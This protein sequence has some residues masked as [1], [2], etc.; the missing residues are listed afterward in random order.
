MAKVNK[1]KAETKLES[2]KESA[3]KKANEKAEDFGVG[4]ESGLKNYTE[5][6]KK[7]ILEQYKKINRLLKEIEFRNKKGEKHSVTISKKDASFF[8]NLGGKTLCTDAAYSDSGKNA[9][10]VEMAWAQVDGMLPITFE[11]VMSVLRS[12]RAKE[13]LG[14]CKNNVKIARDLVGMAHLAQLL[15]G[16][17]SDIQKLSACLFYG[18]DIDSLNVMKEFFNVKM[19]GEFMSSLE[20][21]QKTAKNLTR[22]EM[23]MMGRKGLTTFGAASMVQD[24]LAEELVTGKEVYSF[25]TVSPKLN[26]F[27]NIKPPIPDFF[28]KGQKL[29]ENFL[30][31]KP[32][33]PQQLRA[34]DEVLSKEYR[35]SVDEKVKTIT[36]TIMAETS[37]VVVKEYVNYDKYVEYK[38]LTRVKNDNA[39]QLNAFLTGNFHELNNV[40]DLLKHAAALGFTKEQIADLRQK[41]R[42]ATIQRRTAC[43]AVM[44]NEAIETVVY[45]NNYVEGG[46]KRDGF[47]LIDINEKIEE[48]KKNNGITVLVPEEV[49]TEIERLMTRKS[50]LEDCMKKGVPSRK[51]IEITAEEGSFDWIVQFY[52]AG[53]ADE[54]GNLQNVVKRLTSEISKKSKR[55]Q[56]EI[57][58]PEVKKQ[59]SLECE[60][61]VKYKEI[62]EERLKIFREDAEK[63]GRAEKAEKRAQEQQTEK[64]EYVAPEVGKV[65][66]NSGDSVEFMKESIPKS[67]V[68]KEPEVQKTEGDV[69]KEIEEAIKNI[70][71]GN[72]IA[73]IGTVFNQLRDFSNMIKN[74]DQKESYLQFIIDRSAELIGVL[75]EYKPNDKDFN[76]IKSI[77]NLKQDIEN[78]KK[79]QE[80]FLQKHKERVVGNVS[81][82]PEVLK[83]N[84]SLLAPEEE[85]VTESPTTDIVAEASTEKKGVEIGKSDALFD[86]SE[87]GVANPPARGSSL[88]AEKKKEEALEELANQIGNKP[89]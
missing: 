38:V 65:E 14:I 22:D 87:N 34:I 60:K 46:K 59:L 29:L 77:R 13:F 50:I 23:K 48:F 12:E 6:Q 49:P 32:K 8:P 78:F 20:E 21:I 5:K 18:L 82:A 25:E 62:I 53:F 58:L 69:K 89:E 73:N 42:D 41:R 74:S 45:S 17:A 85:P 51:C 40:N 75:D 37:P 63:K 39:V 54:I 55:I 15:N 80:R 7:Q 47:E 4:T 88:A 52:G 28:D 16:N 3:T 26:E 27:K 33:T 76:T 66:T 86:E 84:E 24:E 10:S 79:K 43:K 64:P 56:N 71:K 83:D 2:E 57:L 36:A 1:K 11:D 19:S 30:D 67:A 68:V 9:I 61:L 72:K 70:Q 44:E 31:G 35:A 81:K